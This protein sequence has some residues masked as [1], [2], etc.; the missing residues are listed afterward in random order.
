[1]KFKIEFQ[2]KP[3]GSSRPEDA[4][5]DNELIFKMGEFIPIP[6]VGDS[7]MYKYGGSEKDF[8]VVSRH[9]WY[10]DTWAGVNI[11]VTDIS[12]DE[13]ATRLIM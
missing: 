4:V 11:V 13:M 12:D 5:Q 10:L 7:V 8:K 9:F 3:A 1:M 6:N 2:Y